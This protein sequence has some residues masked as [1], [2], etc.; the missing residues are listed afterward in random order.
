MPPPLETDSLTTLSVM[1][2]SR[3]PYETRWLARMGAT[4]VL[5]VNELPTLGTF[6]AH[7]ARA[8]SPVFRTKVLVTVELVTPM[9][10]FT[11][12]AVWSRMRL[13][14]MVN[15]SMGPSIHAPTLVCCIHT[16]SMVEL[17]MAPPN[18][19]TW[20]LSTRSRMSP[21]TARS[22]TTTF[23]LGPPSLVYLP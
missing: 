16:L 9:W 5:R 23:W 18:A 11:P 17:D 20:S 19:L 10:K 6:S 21:I 22:R 1:T 4:I 15:R 2:M 12:S 3:P 14:L 7:M 8:S 13:F